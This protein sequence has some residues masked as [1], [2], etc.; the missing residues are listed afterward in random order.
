MKWVSSFVFVVGALIAL[1]SHT[2][3][4]N[5]SN[6]QP[7]DRQQPR[8][9]NQ[10]SSHDRHHHRRSTATRHHRHHKSSSKH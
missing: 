3:N 7:V 10:A 2:V 5:Q 4:A 8:V 1:P 6:S 9:S